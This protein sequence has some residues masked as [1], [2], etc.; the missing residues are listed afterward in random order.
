MASGIP[1]SVTF[2][3][4]DALVLARSAFNH[5]MNYRS[6]VMFGTAEVVR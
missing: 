5:S 1:V 4:L 3:L 2:V 6:V